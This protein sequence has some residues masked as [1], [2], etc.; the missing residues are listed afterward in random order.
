MLLIMLRP[1]L[2]SVV[3][4]TFAA[5]L[6]SCGGVLIAHQ[7]PLGH[8][9]KV[10]IIEGYHRYYFIYL[11]EADISSVDGT[12]PDGILGWVTTAHLTPG[13]HW[14]EV[15]LQNYFGGGGGY[16]TCAFDEEF[17]A[18][19]Q[20]KI[21]PHSVQHEESWYQRPPGAWWQSMGLEVW[22][23][24]SLVATRQV[25]MICFGGTPSFCKE[26]KDCSHHQTRKCETVLGSS[27]GT[28]N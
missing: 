10:A 13:K 3:F 22:N 12:R 11:E 25:R 9:G 19:H 16:T 21:K 23:N 18:G 8:E 27:F 20:Y 2:K 15:V 26:D 28:C 7:G 24:E 4:V 14:I 17:E 1:F 5:L 6:N